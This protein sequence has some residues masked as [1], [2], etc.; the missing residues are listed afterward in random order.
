MLNTSLSPD[1]QQMANSIKFVNGIQNHFLKAVNHHQQIIKYLRIDNLII[2]LW[3]ANETLVDVITPA[4]THL[5]IQHQGDAD[6]TI[7]FWDSQ[8]TQSPVVA[9]PYPHH[10]YTDRGEIIHA[11]NHRVYA[12]MDLHTKALNVL[13]K[14]QNLAFY[15]TRDV[16]DLPWWASG[17]PLQ[18]IL[19]WWTFERDYQLTHAAGIS[20]NN[21][22]VLLTGKGGSGKSTTTLA[23]LQSGFDYIGE[24]YCLLQEG[25]QPRIHSV[26]NSAKVTQQTLDFFPELIPHIANKNRLPQEKALLFQHE[27]Y[28]ERIRHLADLAA[29]IVPQVENIQASWLE[30][31]SPEQ[32]LTALTVT[33]MWQLV[34]S[35]TNTFNRLKTIA[36]TLPAYRLHLGRDMKNIPEIIGQLL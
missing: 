32:V 24:D 17:S 28:P 6:L 33:T 11:N 12:L 30:P 4:L 8:S 27:I 18:Y 36:N 13:D 31:V 23:C 35:S 21:K 15:W 16:T 9:P 26:Y 19:H 7:C 22:A 14:E 29:I 3:F 20:K 1:E 34:R 25:K 2:K 10:F 5:E